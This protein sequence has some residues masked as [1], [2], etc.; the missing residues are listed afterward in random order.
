M[1]EV[2]LKF[3]NGQHNAKEVLSKLE[4]LSNLLQSLTEEKQ[5]LDDKLA[6]YVFFPLSHVFRASQTTPLRALE[7][8]VQCLE[9]LLQTGWQHILNPDLG[10]QLLIL[11]TFIADSGPTQIKSERTSE[12]LQTDAFACLEALFSSLGR[13]TA[14]KNSLL[15]PAN[16]P[17]LGHAITVMLDGLNGGTSTQ[18][19]ILALDALQA[20]GVC[21]LNRAIYASFLPGIVSSLS[22]VISDKTKMRRS[23]K[24]IEKSLILL[25]STIQF[26][27][28]DIYLTAEPSHDAENNSD[29]LLKLDTSWVKA[30][31]T[32]LKLALANVVRQRQHDRTEVRRAVF[33]V[34]LVVLED[35]PK[36]L[37]ESIGMM[38]ETLI[39]LS[40]LDDSRATEMKL[41]QIISADPDV[42]EFI[43]TSLYNWLV[44]LPRMMLS[45]DDTAKS[46]MV[47]KI[48]VA[49]RLLS[50]ADISLFLVDD[51]LLAT[52]QDSVINAI[53]FPTKVDMLTKSLTSVDSGDIVDILG[54]ESVQSFPS[55]LASHK[56]AVDTLS[57]LETLVRH[58]SSSARSISIARNS[59]DQA[60][61]NQKNVGLVSFWLC[62][63]ILRN[64]A[65]MEPRFEDFT[66]MDASSDFQ[67]ELCEELYS[68]ALSVLT[69]VDTDMD[70]D[71][72][73]QAI[74]L[75]TLA[76]QAAQLK[77][78]F[79]IELVDALYPVVHLVG[80]HI[81][82]LRMH[83]FVCLDSIAKACEY[84]DAK[85]LLISNV[86]Y[87]VNAVG[88]K[89]NTFDIA[90]QAPQ[91]LLMLI[92]L[93]GPSLLPYLDD[94]VDSVFGALECFHGYA[95]LVELLFSVLN[96]VVEEGVKTPQFAITTGEIVSHLT[97]PVKVIS[98]DDVVSSLKRH[99]G[100]SY[101]NDEGTEE[102]ER[103][104]LSPNTS[105]KPWK[106][107]ETSDEMRTPQSISDL[108]ESQSHVP[109]VIE[110]ALTKTYTMLHRIAQLTQHHLPSSSPSIRI[111]LL[112][113]LTNALPY[114]SSHEDTF[115]PLVHLLWPVLIP[116]LADREAYVVS[117]VLNVIS[118]MCQG[119]GDFMT[120]RI[121]TLWPTIRR[122]HKSINQT[123]LRRHHPSSTSFSTAQSPPTLSTT[124]GLLHLS[125][126]QPAQQ[127]RAETR[128]QPPST[129]SPT[130]YLPTTTTLLRASL[131][132][133]LLQLITH[134]HVSE[135]LFSEILTDM[136]HDALVVQGRADVRMALERRN[137]DAVWLELERERWRRRRRQGMALAGS[138]AEEDD[139]DDNDGTAS[140]LG[141]EWAA[142]RPV[143]V[144]GGPAFVEVVF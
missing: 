41:E 141:M 91:V 108:E 120:G 137:P 117:G 21:V 123:L 95:N 39:S 26:V 102:S 35:C 3:L 103:Y 99:H 122:L 78:E 4:E 27:M 32:Q 50:E 81:Q 73:L 29:L 52:L 60:R 65:E 2:A 43:R 64:K 30:T 98:V 7:L 87:L 125:A 14:T 16:V 38:L 22:Q 74:A 55:V 97:P 12:E 67:T 11:L 23:F 114:L 144:V 49:F 116:R 51:V 105:Q 10:V 40:Q 130:A 54:R 48:C 104:G 71:W 75:E 143:D 88:V 106:K 138:T 59:L 124:S 46:A 133:F 77:A 100:A 25:A 61:S 66:E 31:A 33:S 89:L 121:E 107:L 42:A 9:I 131:T 28:S 136:L 34:C 93:C 129:I 1:N 19:Q 79:R 15:E 86:D 70:L 110:P 24:V 84:V 132:A 18:V 127:H 68:F 112:T 57:E 140:R 69:R 47:G 5:Y 126:P 85:E 45:N 20:F 44:A 80:S 6:E 134:A 53:N 139:D 101:S 8:A 118:I 76:F 17:A 90:P 56:S 142:K 72:R 92:K 13:S 113:L 94:L 109:E 37:S 96:G 63:C 62:L 36:T 58:I 111:S 82:P 135:P 119:A 115:L 128:R 83:A